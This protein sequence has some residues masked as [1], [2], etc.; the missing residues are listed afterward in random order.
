MLNSLRVDFRRLLL[1]KG[2]I[3]G[4]LFVSVIIPCASLVI[5]YGI[6]RLMNEEL[7]CTISDYL[8]YPRTAPIYIAWCATMFLTAE[9]RE[10]ILRNKLISGKDR[11]SILFSYCILVSAVAV[12]MQLLSVIS[13]TLTAFL[14][15][16]EF[17]ILTVTEMTFMVLVHVLA[18]IAVSA[19]MVVICCLLGSTKAG[20][21]LPVTIAVFSKFAHA[22]V[23]EKLYPE[24][25]ICTLE[26]IQLTVYSFIDKYVP[27]SYLMTVPDRK[28]GTYMIGCMGMLLISLLIGINGFKK[29][30]IK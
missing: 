7:T 10:G 5:S 28:L 6:F 19:F 12:A 24:S 18:S 22:F 27:V 21:I 11:K 25:G 9:I 8:F 16:L 26:G 15:K 20:I 29:I 14:C 2:Y 13:I 23:F 1:T 3:A 30:D 17:E 4:I